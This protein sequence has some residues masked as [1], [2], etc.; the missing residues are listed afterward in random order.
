MCGLAL[1][2]QTTF[3]PCR[4]KFILIVKRLCDTLRVVS[5]YH[6][7]LSYATPWSSHKKYIIPLFFVD[8]TP[9]PKIEERATRMDKLREFRLNKNKS[10]PLTIAA[11][12]LLQDGHNSTSDV[13]A[14]S[15]DD[16]NTRIVR[17]AK[18]KKFRGIVSFKY[19]DTEQRESL[20]YTK[21][22]L[23]VKMWEE[24]R[25]IFSESLVAESDIEEINK[26][27][28]QSCSL[29][30]N[31]SMAETDAFLRNPDALKEHTAGFQRLLETGK[32][33]RGLEEWICTPER[34]LRQKVARDSRI[35]LIAASKH[36]IQKGCGQVEALAEEYRKK[37]HAAMIYARLMAEVDA[38]AVCSLQ[39]NA[40]AQET[41]PV[42]PEAVENTSIAGLG[43]QEIVLPAMCI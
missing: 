13:S 6:V 34:A 5:R 15:V 19:M 18:R 12:S 40:E 9:G 10:T 37:S 39:E 21:S 33:D 2:S 24:V 25:A 4:F 32:S 29:S 30:T 41:D 3:A 35:A 17:F 20:W 36:S 1:N 16:C 7:V 11:T 28:H 43:K 22:D 31:L 26:M 38:Q 27:F 14:F 23:R 42:S 8:S